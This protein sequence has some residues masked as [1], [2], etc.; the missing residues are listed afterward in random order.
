MRKLEGSDLHHVRA[1]D[2]WVMLRNPVEAAAE[3]SALSPAAQDHPRTLEVRWHVQAALKQWNAALATTERL[4]KLLPTQPGPW[5]HRS[6]C[7][8]ELR[9]TTEAYEL[10]APAAT[11]FPKECGIPYNLACYASRGNDLDLARRW[12]A[13][14]VKRSN[15]RDIQEMALADEDLEPLWREIDEWSEGASA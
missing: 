5:I 14:A 13:E 7:L 8:H 1:A 2:G 9:R 15:L 4:L 12:L 10:L 6:Y 11:R 3:L